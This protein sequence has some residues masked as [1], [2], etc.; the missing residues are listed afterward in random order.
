MPKYV[1]TRKTMLCLGGIC[2]MM[3][4]FR[5]GGQVTYTDTFNT[6]INYLT[7]AVTG[8][9]SDGIYFGGGIQ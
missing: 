7:N 5:S 3:N 6:P 8:T 1:S 4:A 2:V 9:I